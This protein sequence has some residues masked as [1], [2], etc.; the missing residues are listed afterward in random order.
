[1]TRRRGL[2]VVAAALIAANAAFAATTATDAAPVDAARYPSLA[3]LTGWLKSDARE[4][5]NCSSMVALSLS[6]RAAYEKTQSEPAA[7]HNI[8]TSLQQV[9]GGK[10]EASVATQLASSSVRTAVQ[11]VAL[12]REAAGMAIASLCR[13]AVSRS[14][15]PFADDRLVERLV[16]EA[17]ACMSGLA[18]GT[19]TPLALDCVVKTFERR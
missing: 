4:A 16:V 3:A 18:S 5:R 15:R 8:A 11:F 9:S 17:R 6:A 12:P 7:V 19:T 2:A 14:D 13:S 1:M 10:M